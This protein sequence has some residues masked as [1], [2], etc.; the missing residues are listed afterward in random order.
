M[1]NYILSNTIGVIIAEIATLPICTVKTNYQTQNVPLPQIVRSI[2]S[3]HGI[4]GFYTA[5]ASA[6]A[7]QTVSTVSKYSFY[8][9]L[10]DYRKTEQNDILGNSVNGAISGILGSLFAHPIDVLKNHQQRHI[11]LHQFTPSFKNF[12]RGYSQA[13]LKNILLYSALYPLY[14]FYQSKFNN[15]LISA[16]LTTMTTTMYLQPIDYYKTNLMA[17]KTPLFRNAYKGVSLNLLRTIPH[18]MITMVIT[19]KLREI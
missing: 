7:S 15:P 14:D 17:G 1:A 9:L 5:S 8:Q 19:E 12:Y 18:F 4:K 16:P 2:Y 11:K 13:F 6:I 3:I 10:R